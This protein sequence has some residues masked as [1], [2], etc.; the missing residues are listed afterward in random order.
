MRVYRELNNLGYVVLEN[1]AIHHWVSI[2]WNSIKVK[3]TSKTKNWPRA[4]ATARTGPLKY[5]LRVY[6]KASMWPSDPL[7]KRQKRLKWQWI[8]LS[9]WAKSILARSHRSLKFT[10][11]VQ[12]ERYFWK[13]LWVCFWP[14]E[15]TWS[16][17]TCKKKKNHIILQIIVLENKW[18][19]WYRIDCAC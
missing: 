6:S 9:N 8:D 1:S 19:F 11:Y 12:L 4:R 17:C 13:E 2:Q 3:K 5:H 7:L 15:L 14:M 16:R 18:P 10:K